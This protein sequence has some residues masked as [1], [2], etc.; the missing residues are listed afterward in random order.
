VVGRWLHLGAKVYVFEDPTA[1]SMSRQGGVT[2]LF[3]VA[4]QA[5][6]AIVVVSTEFEE[7]AKVCPA[8]GVRPRAAS[9]LELAA[10]DLS[11]GKSSLP[12]P[13]QHRALRQAAPPFHQSGT[14]ALMQSIKSARSS[15]QGRNCRA[16]A[17]ASDR[18]FGASLWLPILTILLIVFLLVASAGHVPDRA[19]RA[20]DPQRQGNH[21]AAVAGSDIADEC[22][23][24]STS[25]IGLPHRHVHILAIILQVKF[26]VPWPVAILIVVACGR[27]S[28]CS[29]GSSSKSRNRFRSCHARHRHDPVRARALAHRGAPDHGPLPPGFKLFNTTVDRR[30]F[31]FPPSTCSSW[32][33]L[34]GSSSERASGRSVCLRDWRHEKAAALNGIPGQ[35]LTSSAF[36]RLRDD[37]GD[38]PAACW[39]PSSGSV[40]RMSGS[41]YLLPRSLAHFSARTTIKPGRVNVWG[42]IFGVL[43]LAVGISGIQ[44]TRGA[45]LC[46]TPVQRHDVVISIAAGSLRRQR[47]RTVA[48]TN[49]YRQDPTR[50]SWAALVSSEIAQLPVIDGQT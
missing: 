1:A 4:L 11:V 27:W 30:H 42:T 50:A 20:L 46:R 32:P 36:C 6:A 2:G 23:A 9:S 29:T 37:R 38:S 48:S 13:S 33:S 7:V 19:Q 8:R 40:R 16:I 10:A 3:D 49:S 44:P 24:V 17:L 5:C 25:T 34:S 26:G 15:L 47:R 12:R 39:P 31:R 22:Q 18:T 41:D 43:I 14:G 21:R 45:F 35:G 28:A